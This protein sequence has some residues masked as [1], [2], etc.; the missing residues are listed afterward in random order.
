MPIVV[1]CH[2]CTAC[3]RWPGEVRLTAAEITRLAAFQGLSES[4]FIQQFT[5]LRQDRRG[6]ALQEKPNGECIFLAGENCSV[7]AVKPQQCLDFPNRWINSLWGKVPLAAIKKDYPMLANCAAFKAFLA[8]EKDQGRPAGTE[9]AHDKIEIR[10]TNDEM[11][12][13]E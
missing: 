11:G 8:S 7:Q 13:I 4:G 6:L 10:M 9:G 5:R 12:N 1:E 2:R 3:C